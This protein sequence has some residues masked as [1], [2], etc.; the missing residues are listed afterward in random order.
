MASAAYDQ[1][2]ALFSKVPKKD[3]WRSPEY[4]V[5]GMKKFRGK[6]R[7]VAG[8]SHSRMYAHHMHDLC[9]D[10]ILGYGETQEQAVEMMRKKLSAGA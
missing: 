6:I 3:G 5:S 2:K 8:Y 1:I 7:Y 9:T 4:G 10:R